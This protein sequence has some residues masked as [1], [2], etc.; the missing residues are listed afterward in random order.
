MSR[1]S[2]GIAPS[3]GSSIIN[4]VIGM[5]SSYPEKPS[6]GT[7]LA[8][9]AADMLRMRPIWQAEQVEAEL[10][11]EPRTPFETWMKTQGGNTGALPRSS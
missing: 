6:V 3:D 9:G 2:I 5:E 10:R 7:G 11:G 8:G 4:Q 1:K